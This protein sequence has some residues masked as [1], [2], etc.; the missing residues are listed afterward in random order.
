MNSN[1]LSQFQLH[2]LKEFYK[3][4]N[5]HIEFNFHCINLWSDWA[6]PLVEERLLTGGISWN[7]EQHFR[8]NGTRYVRVIDEPNTA[9]FMWECEVH[10]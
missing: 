8:H 10:M 1:D 9:N 6:V 5:C 2:V 4:M 3:P 7:A